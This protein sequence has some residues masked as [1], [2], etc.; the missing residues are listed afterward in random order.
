MSDHLR[1]RVRVLDSWDDVLLRV[2][3][4]TPIADIK[5][6][7]LDAEHVTDD[8]GRYLVKFRGAVLA[9]EARTVGDARVPD[10]GAMIVMRRYR[11]AVR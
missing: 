6:R 5:R 11:S 10:D 7:A 8:P 1:I 2:P 3:A 9:D 4:S